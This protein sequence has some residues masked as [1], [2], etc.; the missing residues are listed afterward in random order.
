MYWRTYGKEGEGCSLKLTIPGNR[1]R[2]VHYGADEVKCPDR[3]LKSVM[4]TLY[5]LIGISGQPIIDVQEKLAGIVVGHLEKIQYLFKDKA[6][7]Y[8]NECRFVIPESETNRNKIF[9]EYGE[10]SNTPTRIRHYY[11]DKDLEIEEISRL[12]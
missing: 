7:Q 2:K 12:G 11:E 5:P 1:L 9:F 4:D 3:L 10:Q 6:Y 8:E